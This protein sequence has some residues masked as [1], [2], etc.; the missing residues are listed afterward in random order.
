MACLDFG[1]V[2]LDRRPQRNREHGVP[3]L[4]TLAVA[5]QDLVAL[6][7]QVLD[8]ELKPFE[9]PHPGPVEQAADEARRPTHTGQEPPH[10][11]AAQDHGQTGGPPRPHEAFQPGDLE[12]QRLPVQEQQRRERLVLGGGRDVTF[13]GE[14]GQERVDLD[15]AHFPRMSPAVEEDEA[16]DPADVG[17]LGARRVVPRSQRRAHEVEQ[18][19]RA[20]FG[21]RCKQ[22]GDLHADRAVHADL[23]SRNGVN[24]APNLAPWRGGVK[25]PAAAPRGPG[26]R[27]ARCRGW[28]DRQI[29]EHA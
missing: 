19:R 7:I 24:G 2:L 20:G 5:D 21:C 12:A 23:L 14:V 18:A 29:A 4:P 22:R 6:E 10:L 8:P 3:V 28:I 15:V 25:R 26:R 17:I 13:D 1:E 16:P 9:Q 11:V 27:K